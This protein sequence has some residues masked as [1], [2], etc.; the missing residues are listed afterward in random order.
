MLCGGFLPR[1]RRPPSE[2]WF[3]APSEAWSHPSL[4]TS[5]CTSEDAP[6]FC[7]EDGRGFIVAYFLQ[8]PE[9]P[10]LHIEAFTGLGMEA[11][12]DDSPSEVKPLWMQLDDLDP[13]AQLRCRTAEN[14]A[15]HAA[16]GMQF[17]A[18][19]ALLEFREIS[20]GLAVFCDISHE[21]ALDDSGWPIVGALDLCS[22]SESFEV[23]KSPEAVPLAEL[24]SSGKVRRGSLIAFPDAPPIYLVGGKAQLF[25]ASP[26]LYVQRLT[27][28]GIFC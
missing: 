20:D 13:G 18:S 10:D 9:L 1:A 6:C 28:R 14:L 22:A 25:Q 5:A 7:T 2:A 21:P 26:I 15:F 19:G 17:E 23:V 3:Q 27:H 11:L 8:L 16:D 24:V 4:G 12:F